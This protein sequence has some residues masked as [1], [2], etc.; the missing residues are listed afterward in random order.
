MRVV[1]QCDH[2]WADSYEERKDPRGRSYFWNSSVFTLGNTDD[3][4]DVAALR[5]N[6]ITVTPLHYDLTHYPQLQEW[7]VKEWRIDP[8]EAE[9]KA[10]PSTRKQDGPWQ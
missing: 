4:T 5:D 1:R 7:Q 2:G 10:A 9:A 6:Y 8:A 3:D